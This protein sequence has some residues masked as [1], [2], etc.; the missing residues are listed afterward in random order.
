MKIEYLVHG[1]TVATNAII[2]KKVAPTGFITTDGFRD[3]L[4]IQRQIRPTLYDLHF[5]KP[6]PL[7]PRYLCFGITERLDAQGNVLTPLDEDALVDAVHGDSSDENVT[8]VA[9]CFLH[10]YINPAHEKRAGEILHEVFPEAIVSLSSEVAPEFREYFRASTTV[11]NACIR[12]IVANYLRRIEDRLRE[13][14]SRGVTARHAEQRRGIHL[15]VG[16]R[17]ARFHGRV[18]SRGGRNRG[19][20]PWDGLGTPGCNF[21]RHGRHYGKGG[22]YSKRHAARDQGI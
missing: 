4:E 8:A 20:L 11:I 15:R 19:N 6:R 22:A 7:A 12:P 10:S 3:L 9:V 21:L 14:G 5:E 13:K 17:K 18:R 1:T 16:E 2:E